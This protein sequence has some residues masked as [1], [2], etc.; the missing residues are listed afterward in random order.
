MSAELLKAI[1][2]RKSRKTEFGYG[3]S[4]ADRYVS[5]LRDCV[6]IEAC[7]K[8]AASRATSFDD[9]LRKAAQTLVYSNEDTVVDSEQTKIQYTKAKDA[10]VSRVSGIELPKNTLMVFRHVLTTPRKDRDGDILRTKG[11][12]VDPKMLL[13]W[14]HVHTL[15]IGKMLNIAEHNDERLSLN[16]C[17]ID[18]NQLCH[19]AAVMVDNGMGRFS[20]GFGARKFDQIKDGETEDGD[21]GFDITEFEVMEESIVSVPSNVDA[22]TDE[23]L[24]SLVESGKLKSPLLKTIGQ[25]IR[26]KRSVSV[27]VSIDLKLSVNG[28]PVNAKEDNHA[29]QCGAC[30]ASG[31]GQQGASNEANADQNAKGKAEDEEVK[32]CPECDGTMKDGV[33]QDCGYEAE[34]SEE[35]SDDKASKGDENLLADMHDAWGFCP[36][37]GTRFETDNTA[38][39]SCGYARNV[40][41]KSHK[42]RRK[43]YGGYLEGSWEW[44]Q[45]KLSEKAKRYLLIV[46]LG[47]GE[48]DWVYVM[49]T[50]ADYCVVNHQHMGDSTTYRIGWEMRDG[51]PEFTG[52]AERVTIETTVEIVAAERARLTNLLKRLGGKA[53]RTLS[54]ANEGKIRNAKEVID[55]AAGMEGVPRACKSMIR[56][57]SGDLGSVLSSLGEIEEA[58]AH[59]MSEAT[60]TVESAMALVLSSADEIQRQRMT[61]A[62]NAMTQVD[63]SR[64]FVES[65]YEIVK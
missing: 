37:C 57:A 65:F 1:R 4:T 26:E 6:G 17:I 28:N 51:E 5:S 53:G 19:D 46:G 54:K 40:P 29:H 39:A 25:S 23:I 58:S 15:P 52:D 47:V 34:D 64:R 32:K 56:E 14:Q 2:A 63:S 27:P 61:Q 38:C 16:S 10:Q 31:K 50:Y 11:A 36:K 48:N 7:N 22:E 44:V 21:V 33:C 12:S 13:L 18:I 60:V 24:L 59:G 3:I 43:M 45:G 49:A 42:S 30:Q 20:H 55:E 9:L 35:E 8:Y 62:L 41:S